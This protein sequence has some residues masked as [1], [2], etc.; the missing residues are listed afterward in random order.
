MT[1]LNGKTG[2]VILFVFFLVVFLFSKTCSDLAVLFLVLVAMA[3]FRSP[4][5][6][7]MPDVTPKPLRSKAN[8]IINLMGAIGG[9]I[10]LIITS[11]M[12][13]SA[14]TSGLEHIDYVPIFMII[15]A[16]MAFSV[17]LLALTVNEKKITDELAKLEE[18]EEQPADA[19]SDVGVHEK[20]KPEVVRSLMFLLCSISLWF[21][22]YNAMTTWFS[23]FATTAWNMSLGAANLCLTVATG[24]AILSYIPVGIISSKIGRKKTIL[25]GTVL[26]ASCFAV[27]F[28][29]T[30][31]SDTFNPVLYLIFALVGLAWAA[32]NVNSLPMVVE[33]CSNKDIGKYTGYYYTFSMAAQIVTPI[34]S[35]ILMEKIGLSVLFP[36]SA[37]FVL[38]STITMLF[39]M[40]GDSKPEVPRDK[41]EMIGGADD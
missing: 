7:L 15:S 1:D 17:V 18:E 9:V 35:G 11:F 34:L 30:L 28:L 39:V 29:F 26:L 32:I 25:A 37:L 36:Y 2:S 40:H 20:M 22:G 33:M 3:S 27:S 12:Y 21:I 6:A 8:A 16:I 14:K 4:A 23:T 5:V 38:A 41:I 19:A 24:G 31:M 10:Y 13:S